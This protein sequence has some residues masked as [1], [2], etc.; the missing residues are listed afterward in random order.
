MDAQIRRG[1]TGDRH[2]DVLGSVSLARVSSVW[3]RGGQFGMRSEASPVQPDANHRA[4]DLSVTSGGNNG[5]PDA[6]YQILPQAWSP[7]SFRDGLLAHDDSTGPQ[8]I[9]I[10]CPKQRHLC[11]RQRRPAVH[12]L[13]RPIRGLNFGLFSNVVVVCRHYP[14]VQVMPLKRACRTLTKQHE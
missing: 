6:I 10:Y 1:R 13:R 14:P 8:F 11:P 5:H 4:S 3:C 12:N 2:L 9:I 7:Y